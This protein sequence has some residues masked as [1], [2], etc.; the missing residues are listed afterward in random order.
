M[1][2]FGF[3]VGTTSVGFAAIDLDEAKGRGSILRMGSRIFPEAR[4]PDG[5]PLNQ[6]RRT[7]RMMRRQLRRRKERRRGLNEM[8]AVAGLLPGFSSSD[9]N[10]VMAADPYLLRAT[11]LN[12]PLSPYEIGRALYHLAKRR[13]F[14]ARDLEEEKGGEDESSTSETTADEKVA[15]SSRDATLK[16]LSE[17]NT[18]LGGW[19]AAKPEG[20]RKRGIHA[21]RD[22]V[23]DEFNIFWEAQA[24]Y[25]QNLLTPAL[26]E[27]AEHA[28]FAQ[29]PVFWRVNTLGQCSL[30][31]GAEL[32]P[33]GSWLS[34]QRRMLEKLN[35]LAIAGGNA[36]PLDGAERAAILAKLQTQASMSW[37]GVRRT[38]E[39]LFKARGESAKTIKFNLEL[40]GDPKLLGN[41]LEAKLA[42]IFGSSW[43]GHPN[44]V[45]IRDEVQARLWAA[46]YG[47]IGKQRVVILSDQ[48]REKRRS[49]AREAF[50][51]DFGVSQEQADAL[52]SMTLPQGWEPYSI[53]ALERILPQLEAGERFGTL[54]NSPERKWA[55]W[56][57]ENFPDREQPTGEFLDKLP[58][59]K[60]KDEMRR[61][62]QLRNPTVVRVQNELRKVVNNLIAVHGKPDLIRIELA[63]DVGKS[64]REREE[65]KSA[66]RHQERRRRAAE[67][68]LKSKGIASPSRADIEKWLLWKESQERCPYSGSQIGFDDLFRL[69]LYEVEHIWPLPR[70]LDNGFR[71]KTLCRRDWN[72]KKGKRT[73]FEAFGHTEDWDAIK[74]RLD[75]LLSVKD[76]M[77]PGKVKRF[78]AETM[79]EDFANRQLTDT[80]YGARQAVF[81][82]EALARYGARGACK[83]PARQWP[84]DGAIAPALGTEQHS[85][86]RWRENARRSSPPRD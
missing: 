80:G 17:A 70:S 39:P 50:V 35:N 74:D 45:T 28:I 27:Q 47:R 29:R 12:E 23:A 63:R 11:G 9:W 15:Q 37:P 48:E 3:D 16:A 19:L 14:K 72:Q 1:R 6:Q 78:L 77:P 36:R 22:V 66:M 33:K 69:G 5:T 10:K 58:S 56:R 42:A 54:L 71:N 30:Q 2:I 65:M 59:P 68:D 76:A 61:I 7:K 4:D 53:A 85:L 46:D 41:P 79:P 57:S 52:S 62:A 44:K 83:G 67:T 75:K 24:R 20:A 18:T 25:H 43:E 64:K 31:P 51:R 55:E 32:C 49:Q 8:L 73:P 86:G 81:S 82:Q 38:L 60:D 21:T 34:Q 13:H 26:R 84:G 40:G